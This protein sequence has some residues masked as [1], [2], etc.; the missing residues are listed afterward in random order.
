M[1]G[2]VTLAASLHL[3]ATLPDNPPSL[4]PIAPL[5]EFD[6]SEHPMRM[7]I[8]T[9]PITRQAGWV[10]VPTGPGLGIEIDRAAIA[11]FLVG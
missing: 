4:N 7:E 5:L 6:Q 10:G 11:K 9:E 2:G 8:L 1:W 3:I